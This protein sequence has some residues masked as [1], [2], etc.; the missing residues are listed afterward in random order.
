[1]AGQDRDGAI[2][3]VV[4]LKRSQKYQMSKEEGRKFL[5]LLLEKIEKEEKGKKITI[6][7]DGRKLGLR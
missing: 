7:L 3:L 4:K 1:M 6:L 2:L 5:V